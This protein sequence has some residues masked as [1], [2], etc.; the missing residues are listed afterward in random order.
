MWNS[1]LYQLLCLLLPITSCYSP[2]VITGAPCSTRNQCPID[3]VCIAS[4]CEPAGTLEDAGGYAGAE[5]AP[6]DSCAIATPRYQQGGCVTNLGMPAATSLSVELPHAIATSHVLVVAVDYKGTTASPQFT[7]SLGNRL[8]PVS[9]VSRAETQSS[10]IAYA[11]ITVPGRDTV[12]VSLTEPTNGIGF[13]VHV[14]SGL[15]ATAPFDTFAFEI[16]SDAQLTTRSATTT[17]PNEL[18][19]AHGVI[20]TAVQSPGIG[21]AARQTCN[22]N[23]TEDALAGAPGP[24]TAT[25]KGNTRGSWI[26]SLATFRS[27]DCE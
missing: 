15:S 27:P 10:L 8:L 13:Y 2:H 4:I 17:A 3:Q 20:A 18:L 1:I 7:D 23:M 6:P 5:A 9:P 14:Y 26:A 21:F 25:F 22:A 24:Y 12:T 16:G 19:F 11:P